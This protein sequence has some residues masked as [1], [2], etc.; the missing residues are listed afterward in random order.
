[1]CER[2]ASRAGR[3]V[4]LG[5]PVGFVCRP[6]QRAIAAVPS[7]T[8]PGI[9]VTTL[10]RPQDGTSGHRARSETRTSCSSAVPTRGPVFAVIPDRSAPDQICRG[11]SVGELA[12]SSPAASRGIAAPNKRYELSIAGER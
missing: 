11:A 8:S 1:M 10:A 3:L 6:E 2:V 12:A 5:E 7:G 4:T 9:G